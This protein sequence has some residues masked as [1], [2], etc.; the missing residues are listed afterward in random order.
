M[1]PQP[2]LLLSHHS[3]KQNYRDDTA[4]PFLSLSTLSTVT[5]QLEFSDR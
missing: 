4:V 3:A 1:E 2:K 5:D